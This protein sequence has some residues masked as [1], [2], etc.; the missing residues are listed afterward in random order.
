MIEYDA[1]AW[2]RMSLSLRG[3]VLPRLLPRVVLA[4]LLGVAAVLLLRGYGFHLPSTAHTMLGVA[5]GLLLVF[6]TNTAY[7]RFWEG[8]RLLGAY[9][10]RARDLARQVASYI[11]NTPGTDG[12]E[13][14]NEILR[15]VGLSYAMLCQTLRSER[16]LT[17]IG[18][19]LRDD[20]RA[21][22]VDCAGRSMRMH[23]WLGQAFARAV[24]TGVLPEARLLLVDPNLTALADAWGGAERIARTPI[25]F[26]Y[27]QHIKTFL[28]IFTLSAP[29]A[30]VDAMG[31]LTPVASAILAFALF[32]IEEI[33]VEIEDPFGYD[34][35]DL[36]LDRIGETI[37]RDLGVARETGRSASV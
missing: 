11:D 35:N 15:L 30:M 26:A 1:R 13:Q 12:D 25:P 32:G 27:A 20:E 7:D 29:F 24:R 16:D 21:A 22:L 3:S 2:V 34:P 14:G 18:T 10:N 37:V 9:T 4:A 19:A 6:R 8:R 28:L 36:P 17:P 33:G 23:T 31:P 5:L